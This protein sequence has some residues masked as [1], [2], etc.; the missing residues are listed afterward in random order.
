MIERSLSKT[1]GASSRRV[2]TDFD[3]CVPCMHRHEVG[4]WHL[5]HNIWQTM[6]CVACS[7]LDAHCPNM[8]WPCHAPHA[9]QQML[10]L[11]HMNTPEANLQQSILKSRVPWGAMHRPKCH[12][13][14]VI[15]SQD[16]PGAVPYRYAANACCGEGRANRAWRERPSTTAIMQKRGW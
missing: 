11:P 3:L 13:A 1:T 16:S 8:Q 7:S 15:V 4:I 10:F 2:P 5:A 9:T 6:H 14:S 12:A